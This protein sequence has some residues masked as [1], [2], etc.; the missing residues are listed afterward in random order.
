MNT[1]KSFWVGW[2][3]LIVGGGAAYYFA[4]QSIDADRREKHMQRIMLKKR[5]EELENS[6]HSIPT[7]SES[8]RDHLAAQLSEL[9]EPAP[10]R[11]TPDNE[12]ERVTSKS[13]FEASQPYKARRGDRFS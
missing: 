9:Q 8:P 12:E 7:Q 5:N 2:G 6:G 10:T 3:S 1:V 13:K 11:H 4:K